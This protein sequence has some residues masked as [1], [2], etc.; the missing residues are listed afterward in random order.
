M[1]LESPM[2]L[3]DNRKQKTKPLPT[4]VVDSIRRGLEQKPRTALIVY[5]AD[6]AEMVLLLPDLPVIVGREHPSDVRIPDPTISR[7]HARFMLS[8]GRILVEDLDSTNGTWIAGR[9]IDKAE[10]KLGDE[11][12][13]GSLL[14][15]VQALGAAESNLG[16]ESDERFRMRLDDEVVRAH[17][18]RSRFAVLMVRAVSSLSNDPPSVR[19][20]PD[21]AASGMQT[22]SLEGQGPQPAT[23]SPWRGPYPATHVG[24]W[25]HSVRSL[26]R[27]VDRMALYSR[28]AV[29]IVLPDTG[30]EVAMDLA[31][32]IAVRRRASDPLLLVGMATYP[33]AATEAEKLIELARS[34]LS[35]ASAEQPVQAAKGTMWLPGEPGHPSR[36]PGPGSPEKDE[37]IV[38]GPVMKDLIETV[39]RLAASRIPVILQGETGVGKEVLARL[40]HESGPRRP[41][42]MVCINC[43]AIPP[44]L[45]ESTLF[46]H[47]RGAFTG[48]SQQQKGLFE[49]A[50]GGTVFLD[51]LG[52]LP[53]PAQAALLRVLETKRL[54]RVGST[55][56]IA[57]DVRI[58]AATHR[59]LEHMCESGAFREDLYYRMNTMMLTIPPLRDRVDEIEPLA[60]R[61]LRQANEANHGRVKTIE[62]RAL[63]RLKDYTWPG[64]VREL[65]NAIERAVVIARGEMILESDLPARVRSADGPASRR[66]PPV[67]KD[68]DDT[69]ERFG[70]L[71]DGSRRP[72]RPTPSSE[73]P[74]SRPNS[75]S[76]PSSYPSAPVSTSPI[77]PTPVDETFDFKTKLQRYEA[78]LILEALRQTRWNQTEAARLLGMPLRTLVHKIKVLDIKKLD[79]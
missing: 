61:F 6:G 8:D 69:V 71:F 46:G 32:A 20:S 56:E 74:S 12:I 21:G 59:D 76:R 9:R 31:K 43:G 78:Q 73:L 65:R 11:L 3:N 18:F 24:R 67:M 13:L 62:T 50:D 55:R 52:E 30:Q 60:L 63:A 35:G 42:P 10:L 64:N 57:V 51:E 36:P 27:P 29:Q 53:P 4:S 45:V 47:E 2:S 68:V 25:S 49:E 15:N 7:E 75:S 1:D 79:R 16:L 23:A 17:H 66:R 54:T 72:S 41:R 39:H 58:I 38:A 44:Q 34:A 37:A 28:D 70:E 48:A 40:I 33:D 26:L 14:A 5:H 19:S 77:A 22:R